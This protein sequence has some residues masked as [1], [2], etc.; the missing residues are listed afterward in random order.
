MIKIAATT[1][2]RIA[3]LAVVAACPLSVNW[4]SKT[5]RVLLNDAWRSLCNW[6]HSAVVVARILTKYSFEEGLYWMVAS[7]YPA[8]VRASRKA[9]SW[10]S[11]SNCSVM[12]VPLW[13]SV[14]K[15]RW[16]LAI[17]ETKPGT[18]INAKIRKNQYLLLMILI[19]F[20]PVE[21]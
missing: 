9:L 7:W 20:H 5:W 2:A 16:G 10:I 3:A 4:W 1:T 13:K 21:S 8:V 11:V 17:N 6:S 19:M 14:P 18:M 15:L 12:A